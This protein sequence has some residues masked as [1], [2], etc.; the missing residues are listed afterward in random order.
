M[1]FL[2]V[3]SNYTFRQ[4]WRHF[5][6]IGRRSDSEALQ[7]ELIQRYDGQ[8]AL[9]FSKGRAALSEAVR[10]AT[11]GSGEVAV[12]S[13]TCFVVIEAIKAAGCQ[14]LYID[15]NP[16]SLQF[17]AKTLK[18]TIEGR[19][20]RAVI[21]QNMLGIPVDI[22]EML[23]V[24]KQANTA[25]IEDLAH[26]V[27]GHYAD[28]R[29]IGTIGDYTMLS[30]GRDKMIDTING[31]ALIVRTSDV[32]AAIKPPIET[33]ALF[34]QFRDRLYPSL[35]WKVRLLFPSGLG[36]YLLAVAYKLKLAIRSADGGTH[37]SLKLPHWQARLALEQLRGIKEKVEKRQENQT[38]YL[39]AL[40][41]FSPDIS[42]NGVRLPLVVKNRDAVVTKLKEKG[43]FVEDIWYDVPVS[44]A[45][46]YG[47]VNFPEVDYP[48]ATKMTQHILNLPT[49][50]LVTHEDIQQISEIVLEEAE[51]WK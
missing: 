26:A 49:H 2:S 16:R 32:G 22:D 20:V 18:N 44:P 27:G 19:D 34:Q 43:Y 21:I 40:S 33:V 29:E 3:G 4:A 30:F 12:T 48:F 47:L 41:K 9:L 11:G 8:K 13:M 35:A 5:W 17:D 51:E 45:R 10:L 1:L 15:I 38:L 39:E 31:G 50:Q 36:K 42:S 14:P 24:A 28:G 7:T 37:P 25:V 23:Q 6:V 46:L